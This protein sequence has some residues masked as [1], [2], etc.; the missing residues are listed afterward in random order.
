MKGTD[1][2]L[3]IEGLCK[4]FS[5]VEVLRGVDFSLRRGEVRA[6][7]GENGA[8]KS[9]LIKLIAGVY[10]PDSG[11]LRFEGADRRFRRPIDAYRAGIAVVYQETSLVPTASAMQN[12]FLGREI[13]RFGPVLDE[14]AMSREYFAVAG[15]L[16]VSIPPGKRVSELGAAEK[17][18]VEIMK[19]V[20]RRSSLLIMDEPTDSLSRNEIEA[21]FGVVSDLKAQGMTIIYITHF[22]GEVSSIA[23][24]ATVLR[25]GSVV[26]TRPVTRL[27]LRELVS[28]M[29]GRE[30]ASRAFAA[31]A[32]TGAARLESRELARRGEF[33]GISFALRKGEVLGVVGLVGSGK[34]ELARA[35]AGAARPH[36][37]SLLV[38]GKHVRFH[39]PR[40]AVRAG[41][42]MAPE[43]RKSQGLILDQEL[44]KNV[45]IASLGRF[46]RFGVIRGRAERRAVRETVDSIS[47]RY[48]SLAQRVKFLS[49]G[50]QQ[51]C[52]VARWLLASPD[53]LVLD[54]PTRG[55]DVG[56]KAEIY[57]IV[58]GLAARGKSVLYFSGEVPEI[59]SVADR[60]IVMQK[61]RMKRTFAT[62]PSE[63]ELLHEMLE[64]DDGRR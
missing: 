34:T 19:A 15:R 59:L 6:L 30:P 9:T 62:P 20:A 51:K 7:I 44:Y 32:A 25:D 57:S 41:I 16:G 43:D 46:A 31:S 54:E 63:D 12:V 17:K 48:A 49:G 28:L 24:S 50:N 8:G 3:E 10:A 56:A 36:S 37:G 53:I 23:D 18:L 14:R 38:G 45:S 55:V 64:V 5:G 42:G 29:L 40:A 4:S 27:P 21:L 35:I 2:V 61:G 33:S 13:S 52:V 1:A 26:A 22:L 47:T 11:K 39:G 58:R 60:V